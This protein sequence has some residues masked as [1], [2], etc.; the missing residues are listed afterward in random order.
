M[1]AAAGTGGMPP[2][3]IQVRITTT[4]A[5][6][7]A[8]SM[9]AVTAASGGMAKG[10]GVGT[11]SARTLGDAM[12]MT[13]S[14]I[15]YTVV[16]VFVN[17]GKQAIQMSRQ[18]ELSFNRIKGLVV[19][20]GD[21][22]DLMKK[23][24]LSLAGETTRAPI[25]LAD[26]LYYITSAG[27]KD[28]NIALEVLESSAKAAAAGLGTTNT[29]ADAVTST[30]N[31]YGVAN[32]SAARATDVLVA[33]VR[34][35]KAEADTFAPALGKVLPVA[36]AYGASFEDVSAAI[37]AL[38]RGGLSAGTAAIY[39]RQTLSQLLKPSK[40]AQEVLKGVGT[41]ADEIRQNVREKGLFA[42][43]IELR[44][45]IGGIEQAGDFTKV[46][47][48]VRALTA[49][50]SLVGP[51]AEENEKIFER[52]AASTGDLDYAFKTYQE[53]IDA[54]FNRALAEQQAA[55]IQLGDAL[56]PV[57]QVFLKAGTMIAKGF[58]K[59]F[60]SGVGKVL[61]YVVTG[62]VIMTSA[63]AMV[64]KTMSAF[65]RLGAQTNMMLFGQ[66]FQYNAATGE[67][68]KYTA[69]TSTAAGATGTAAAATGTWT[70]ATGFLAST[71]R[72]AGTSV[73]YLT[74]A[75]G[76]LMS[77][78]GPI[79]MG[80]TALYLGFMAFKW[81][82]NK[83]KNDGSDALE[84]V[85][86]GVTK[87]KELL[88]ETAKFGRTG[89]I[90]DIQVDFTTSK[91]ED[92]N[93]QLEKE[94]EESSP[95]LIATIKKIADTQGK[96]YAAAYV[97]GLAATSL[98][99][100]TQELK[101]NFV[102]F[103]TDTLKL[104]PQQVTAGAVKNRTG[105]TLTDGL[106]QVAS[107]AAEDAS[108]GTDFANIFNPFGS[109]EEQ[110]AAFAK[111]TDVSGYYDAAVEYGKAF[112]QG[113]QDTGQLNPL[114]ETISKFQ[115]A[116]T[117]AGVKAHDQSMAIS[118]IVGSALTGLK[119]KFD[120]VGDSTGNL[121]NIFN[122]QFSD[123]NK[124]AAED[125]IKN[126]FG[127]TDNTEVQ[128]VYK[129]LQD[130]MKG[131]ETNARGNTEAFTR[132]RKVYDE[133]KASAKGVTTQHQTLDTVISG[134]EDRFSQGYALSIRDLV[135]E[136]D[137]ATNAIKEFQRGQEAL[138]GL[139]RDMTE[140]QIDYRSSIRD[141][142]DDAKSAG[143]DLF[144]G[145]EAA[146]KAKAALLDSMDA[147]L[148]VVNTYAAQMDEE[149][150]AAALGQGMTQI[151]GT[152]IAA[153]LKEEDIMAFFEL[154]NFGPQMLDTLLGAQDTE[155]VAG[156]KAELIGTALTDG[157]SRGI[158][159]GRPAVSKAID[160]LGNDV[161]ARLKIRLGI[162]SP[163]AVM[164]KEVG[165]PT[166]QGFAKGFK[167]E[168]GG[169]SGRAIE[170]SL[171]EA[172][173]KAYKSG[174]RKGAN[175]FYKDFLEKKGDVE[176][177]A[178][179]FVKETIGR[180]KD[181][182]GS[183]GDYIRSQLDFRKA[184]TDLAK[185]INMQ[186]G[187][188]SRRK[189]A[190]REQQYAETRYGMGGGAEVTGYEQSRIDQLQIEFERASRD[191]A[192]GR[193]SYTELVDAEIALYEARAAASEVSDDVLGA[194]NGFI[195]A[196]VELENKQLNLAGAT[197]NILSAYQDVQEAAALLYINHAE[198]G[199]VYNDLAA[200][201]GIASGKLQVGNS[202]LFNLGE[203]VKG[204]GGYTST[205]GG[206]VSTLGNNITTTKGLFDQNLYG[207]D[208]VFANIV[209]TGGSVSALTAS[210]GANFTDLSK[211]LLDEKSE[212]YQNLKSLGPTIFKAIQT[213]AQDALD[214]SP[215]R[216]NVSVN[217]TVTSSGGKGPG[218]TVPGLG[219]Y[220]LGTLDYDSWFAKNKSNLN[221]ETLKSL[222]GAA[223]TRYGSIVGVQQSAEYV[224]AMAVIAQSQYST[225]LASRRI[226]G[227]AVGGP[228]KQE[229]PYLVG[230]RGPEIFVPKVSGTIV[231]N[232]AMDRYTRTREVT[233]GAS[234]TSAPNNIVVTVNNPV[235]EA[236]EDSIT[237]RMKVLANSGL[238]G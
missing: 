213:A 10:L 139:A 150:A 66:Q 92:I 132:F 146:D 99:G 41:S 192:M 131:V 70:T 32:M 193:L 190:A 46:F 81:V 129:K 170:K 169:R 106:I 165:V 30:M 204:L 175:K 123:K 96:E 142:G 143:G 191:Y 67:V 182:I 116:W 93:A 8:R 194:Q 52:M 2:L 166:A 102:N 28:A 14:L 31:A 216:L 77:V 212:M 94:L 183:L 84:S 74:T 133:F 65:V 162:K 126:T 40:Q 159:N 29:V 156:T 130:A 25:E 201:T 179:D 227:M 98:G 49:V 198:L 109:L 64:M 87:V 158:E 138:M 127:V 237:R 151:L 105:D 235:P 101:D 117:K 141:L 207:P 140:A 136:Y 75:M 224:N 145:T 181:I 43:L 61:T 119:D 78:M 86:D 200:A 51:A 137:A 180:M 221:T 163:S 104:T 176:T 23:K 108:R 189:K 135:T 231:T 55:L 223:A 97:R 27:I 26:A 121:A 199:K 6:T 63:L 128:A 80:I 232:S 42:A 56:K 178:A 69:A 53:T 229:T 217:A 82:F 219:D 155:D 173:N 76:T 228:V 72:I 211:G 215:L 197:V 218:A 202:D 225:Y 234:T 38:S 226:K 160:A 7:A 148:E 17:A 18:F 20:T 120:L 58:S 89:I 11:I 19:V 195:D 147:V 203:S 1:P 13:A 230:E 210:I 236:A 12:R 208:G 110:A 149:G 233:Q 45:A 188:E 164:A 85:S 112:T 220:Q 88:N 168:M 124:S 90:F 34:E 59:V 187:L 185:L 5:T 15:K 39:V 36:A 209:K 153:G 4:G 196:T 171:A 167:D 214:K 103:F 83:F 144:A 157:M 95:G 222:Y 172:V 54:D 107:V 122:E 68:L 60:G 3:N 205:V 111:G 134:L 37:A 57:V 161:I 177:P 71:V 44:D 9:G 47:G 21:S 206:Y 16:G 113:I 22:L 62:L 33:T 125:F 100:N 184:Q 114:V 238:F 152:G 154:H 79:M 35:G 91:R 24:V 48:N 73:Y 186:R 174:G 118:D 115:D 50:L